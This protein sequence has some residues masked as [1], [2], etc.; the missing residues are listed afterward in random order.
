MTRVI[1]PDAKLHSQINGL[2][3]SNLAKILIKHA[4][5]LI[6]VRGKFD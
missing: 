1:L 4:E 5:N 3:E 2:V 6:Q